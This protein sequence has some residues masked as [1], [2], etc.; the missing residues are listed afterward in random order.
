M[1]IDKEL[2]I[3]CEECIPYC[4]VGAIRTV[5]W[6]GETRSEV[7]QDECVECGVCMR[8]EVCPV[9]AFDMPELEWP[10]VLRAHFSN[11]LIRHPATQIGG[12]GT[13]EIKTNDVTDRLKPGYAGI[14]VEMGRPGVATRFAD[15]E[16]VAMALAELGVGFEPEN[17]V[18]AIMVD[19]KTGK[20]KDDVLNERV[21]SGIIEFGCKIEQLKEVLGVLK[22]VSSKID[23]VFTLDLACR[24]GEDGS[25]PTVAI[26]KECGFNPR[27]NTKT[28]V[29]LG[30]L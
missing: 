10:R 25:V 6:E 1:N 9:D 20:L 12:R 7:D 22:D 30:R 18:A 26:A 17:P 23:T 15:L 11:P 3:G 24:V 21:L 29:G 28:N 19:P 27:V 4:T 16:T 14:A 13:E 8:A 5:E 2:C